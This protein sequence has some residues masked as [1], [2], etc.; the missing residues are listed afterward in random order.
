MIYTIT[1]NPALDITGVVDNLIPNE[2]SYVTNVIHTPGGN[3][4][5]AGIVAARLGTEVKLSGFLGGDNGDQL[6]GLL[7]AQKL[8]HHFISIS[9]NT[10]MNVTVSNRTTHKQTRLSFPGPRVTT[11]EWKKLVS[12]VEGMKSTE[13]IVILGG[14]LPAGVPASRVSSL[15]RSFRTR[16]IKC[17]VDMPANSLGTVLKAK[18]YF[19]KPNLQEFQELTQTKVTNIHG[20]LRT[21][22]KLRDIVP[23]ICVSSVEGGALLMGHGEVWFGKTP[24][25]SIKSTVGAGDSMVGAMASLLARNSQAPLDELLRIGLAASAASLS[26]PGL[27]LGSKRLIMSFLPKIKLKKN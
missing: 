19:I 24:K 7:E 13:D 3:G 27:N 6:M 10:R 4:I 17:F 16:G 5:N 8:N 25:L 1:F 2:K 14:S 18:P 23:L 12:F 15:V 26:E 20:V 22:S 11:S 9:S 21:A